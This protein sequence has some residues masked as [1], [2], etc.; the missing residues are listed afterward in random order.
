M[1]IVRPS[2]AAM[3]T[4]PSSA[5]SSCGGAAA[6]VAA[7]MALDAAMPGWREDKAVARAA[8]SLVLEGLHNCSASEYV[9]VDGEG[10]GAGAADG[11]GAGVV[12]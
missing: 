12:W 9:Y 6:R 7:S 4:R 8:A 1:A 5:A 11:Y 3:T 2:S 10:N